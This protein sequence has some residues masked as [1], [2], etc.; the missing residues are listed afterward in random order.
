MTPDHET[1]TLEGLEKRWRTPV[2][3]SRPELEAVYNH[4]ADELASVIAGLRELRNSL[5]SD[6]G[7]RH[8]E[9]TYFY[10]ENERKMRAVIADQLDKWLG[11]PATADQKGQHET[12]PD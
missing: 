8:Y 6:P 7:V 5:A 2:A 11:Y 4:C 9:R 10:S 12:D 1:E 3:S